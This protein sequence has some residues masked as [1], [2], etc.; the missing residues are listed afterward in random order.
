MSDVQTAPTPPT[1]SVAPRRGV[2]ELR[3]RI[4]ATWDVWAVSKILDGALRFG[5]QQA[6]AAQDEQQP[7]TAEGEGR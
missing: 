1:P 2:E 5:V 4:V 7:E 3:P 6:R